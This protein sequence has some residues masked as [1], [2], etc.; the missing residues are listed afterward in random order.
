MAFLPS[1]PAGN[2]GGAYYWKDPF[3]QIRNAGVAMY[4]LFIPDTGIT[5]RSF[6]VPGADIKTVM[7]EQLADFEM[8]VDDIVKSGDVDLA[9]V[10]VHHGPIQQR[11]DGLPYDYSEPRAL[12]ISER[13][14]KTVKRDVYFYDRIAPRIASALRKLDKNCNWRSSAHAVVIAGHYHVGRVVQHIEGVDV[15][16]DGS[17]VE[18]RRLGET[19]LHTFV[20]ITYGKFGEDEDLGDLYDGYMFIRFN[21][22]PLS[23]T[24]AVEELLRVPLYLHRRQ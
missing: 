2:P 15:I 16:L 3:P 6:D 12:S 4:G 1:I 21:K 14:A 5:S 13:M 17:L 24:D 9:I 18:V 19:G 7:L 20:D 10:F 22:V 8:W 23:P 11:T